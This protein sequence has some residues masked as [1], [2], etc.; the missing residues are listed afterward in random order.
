MPHPRSRSPSLPSEGEIV[1]PA[2]GT[3]ATASKTPFNGTNIDRPT[4]PSRPLAPRSPISYDGSRSPRR[5][6]SRTRYPSRSRS[7]SPYRDSRGHK[8]RYGDPQNDHDRRTP[9]YESHRYEPSADD[10]RHDEGPYSRRMRSYHDYDQQESYGEGLRYSDDYDQR[11]DKRQRTRSRSRS[12]SPYRDAR[13]SK[14]YSGDDFNSKVDH[15]RPSAGS[16]RHRPSEQVVSERAKSSVAQDSKPGAET[17]EN[18]VQASS[19]RQAFVSNEYALLFRGQGKKF[20]DVYHREVAHP[21]PVEDTEPVEPVNEDDALEARRKRR[22]AIRAKYRNQPAASVGETETDT[23]TPG[24]EPINAKETPGSSGALVSEQSGELLP[25]LSAGQDSDLANPGATADVTSKD[26][27]SAVDFDAGLDMRQEIQKHANVQVE[28]G[29]MPSGAYDELETT[30]QGGPLPAETS[31]KSS[32]TKSGYDMF[33]DDDDDMFAEESD[34]PK[35]SRAPTTSGP[36]GEQLDNMVDDW[37]DAQGYYNVRLG[38]LIDKRYQVQQTLGKG[39]FAAVVRALDSKTGNLVAI[40]VIRN[41]DSMR[42]EG[43]KEIKTLNLLHEAEHGG[44]KHIVKFERYFDHKGHLCLVF[45]NLSM[46][47]RELLKK[48]GKNVGLNL[49]AIRAYAYQM[50]LALSLLRHMNLIHADLK[51]DNML[52]NEQRGL[53]KICDLGSA[54]SADDIPTAPYLA[55]RFYRAPEIILGIPFDFAV[56]TWSIGCTLYELYAGNILFMGRNNNQM[57]RAIQEVRGNYPARLL[58]RGSLRSHHFSDDAVFAS[59]EVNPLTGQT[60]PK[61]IDFK[62]PPRDLKTRLMGQGTRGMSQAEVKELTQFIDFLDRCL[63]LNPEKRITPNEALKHPFL[64][65]S[66]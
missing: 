17:R 23:P 4:R 25:G 11:K 28:K 46:D 40:K 27:L 8:R 18:Q 30:T 34:K 19:S 2:P 16:G 22:E 52:V 57:L 66:V 20:T 39:T 5:G 58:R 10:R 3:K 31:E 42:K 36:R 64:T 38:E 54:F 14:K 32:G 6:D 33:A 61:P 65:S 56:D 47:L 62:K 53:L 55:S 48:F 45:E 24:P 12:R 1:D 35:A 59:F 26:E 15:A 49:R 60:E 29:D 9:R 44:N 43:M 13:K 37:D 63:T 50:F 51:P 41:N 7:R 21:E